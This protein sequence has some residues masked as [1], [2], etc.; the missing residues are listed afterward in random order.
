MGTVTTRSFKSFQ[1][2]SVDAGRITFNQESRH[3]PPTLSEL[4]E[5]VSS[6]MNTSQK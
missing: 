5:Y 2:R 4:N 1:E 3:H 6:P